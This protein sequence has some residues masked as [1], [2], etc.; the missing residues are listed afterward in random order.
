MRRWGNGMRV[1]R[2]G[3][4]RGLRRAAPDLD[5]Q[6]FGRMCRHLGVTCGKCGRRFWPTRPAPHD[7]GMTEESLRYRASAQPQ[8]SQAAAATL[9]TW[10]AAPEA[11][12]WAS[13]VMIVLI[14]NLRPRGAKW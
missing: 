4:L 3:T 12:S 2:S 11:K 8:N 7:S 5:D 9:A 6:A 1:L 14:V 10:K 13:C